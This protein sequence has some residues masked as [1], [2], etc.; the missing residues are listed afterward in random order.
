MAAAPQEAKKQP[1][2]LQ[3]LLSDFSA[4]AAAGFLV[5]P[6]VSAVDRYAAVFFR[7]QLPFFFPF[8]CA[9]RP[10]TLAA[11]SFVPSFLS[12]LAE[13]ASGKEKLFTSFGKSLKEMIVHPIKFVASPQ[14]RWIWL[15]Y[16]STYV[17][18]NS[19]ETVCAEKGINPAFPKWLSTSFTNTVT[20][21][22]KDRAFARLFGTAAPT[23]VP[24]GSYAAWL[25]RDLV[26]MGV[27]FTLPPIVGK[28]ISQVLLFHRCVVL[29]F[30]LLFFV[31]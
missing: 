10:T 18:A 7:S 30:S 20:C 8:D 5:T 26:S 17:A 23:N 29:L 21:I 22:A 31:P 25:T 9:A 3:R 28:Q 4:G 27:F 12:A 14:F 19:C 13:N 2:F 16:G 15:V 6:V 1:G 11:F 24:M